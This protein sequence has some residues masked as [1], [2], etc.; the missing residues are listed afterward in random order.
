MNSQLPILLAICFGLIASSASATT[1]TVAP[2]VTDQGGWTANIGLGFDWDKRWFES[3]RGYLS[4]YWQAGY[5]AWEGGR[6]GNTAH[7]V[8]AAPVFVY[9]FTGGE[10]RPFIEFGIGAAAFSRS[11]VGDR[12]LGSRLH[13]ED[14]LGAGI[15]FG[16]GRRLG[17]RVIHYSNAGLKD[18]NQGI[19]SWSV[20]YSHSF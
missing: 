11:R 12:R 16:N 19:N 5:T 8:S 20:V 13:F 15:A 14:R 4:G 6:V 2:G 17:L 18:P 9:T 10:R 3:E 7:S 1:L